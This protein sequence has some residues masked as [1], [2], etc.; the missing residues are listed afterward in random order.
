MAKYKVVLTKET[1]PAAME[2]IEQHCEVKVWKEAEPIPRTLLLEWLKDAEGL[3]STGDV[4]VDEDLLANA[5]QLRVVAQSSVG[6]DNIDIDA[7]TRRGIPFGNTPGVLVE[8]TA[9]LAFALLLGAARRIHECWDFVKSGKWESTNNI[10]FGVD[11]YGK[12]LG[13][14]GM[15]DIG[16]AVAR[17]A[18]ACGLNI[19]YYNRTRRMDDQLLEARYVDFRDLLQE[20]DFIITLVPLSNQSRGMFGA[21]EFAQMKPSAY[22]INAARGSIVNTEAL[23]EAL[24]SKQIAYAALDVTD[25][26]PLAGDN[27]LLSLPNI[28]I[29]P[30]IG[31]AT[32]ETRNRMAH[33]AADNLLAGLGRQAL[34][35]CVNP[36]V[37]Y[38]QGAL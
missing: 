5:H 16:C 2:R 37:N 33:L 38:P 30:H 27:P 35:T 22:F 1:W 28:L 18:K 25:P 17:R 15:G 11:L 34:P 24:K 21:K 29:T 13:I 19:I 8:T 12:T 20:S 36:T 31:S 4:K 14:V 26:E 7:C 6:Y 32:Y 23:Y 10:P 9:D 3:F